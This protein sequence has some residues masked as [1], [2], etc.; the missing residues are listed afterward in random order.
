MGRI[1]T[2]SYKIKERT[3]F[4]IMSTVW[5]DR[6][7]YALKKEWKNEGKAD[8]DEGSKKKTRETERRE[9]GRYRTK[10]KA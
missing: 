10:K 6:C 1:K 4:P 5:G 8:L 3:K 9:Q 2:R 7:S